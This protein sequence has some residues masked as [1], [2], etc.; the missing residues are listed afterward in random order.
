MLQTPIVS[1][2][3][4]ISIVVTNA[5]NDGIKPAY[6]PIQEALNK[7]SAAGGGTV[8][9]PPGVFNCEDNT[10]VVP[11]NVDFNGASS[12]YVNGGD[13]GSTLKFS[14]EDVICL[15]FENSFNSQLRNMSIDGTELSGANNKGIY[16]KGIWLSNI[17]QISVKG[18][19]PDKG[20]GI[21]YDTNTDYEPGVT[22][23]AQHNKITQVECADG[24]IYFSGTDDSNGVTTTVLDTIRGYK[25]GGKY[26]QLTIINGTVE[27]FIDIGYDFD[28]GAFITLI[29]PTIE[30]PGTVGVSIGSGAS[31]YIEDAVWQGFTGPTR[32]SG[33]ATDIDTYGGA[34]TNQ[35]IMSLVNPTLL[36]QAS[37]FEINGL[38]QEYIENVNLTGGTQSSAKLWKRYNNGALVTDHQFKNHLFI[39]HSIVTNSTS[40]FDVATF[41]I[42]NGHGLYF[43][44]TAEGT[45]VG[46]DQ[47]SASISAVVKRSG[48][49]LTITESA[50]LRAGSAIQVHVVDGGSG[51]AV[52]KFLPGAANVSTA[53]FTIEVRGP[54]L[55]YTLA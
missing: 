20:Y 53:N 49:V 3:D 19:P 21:Y 29:H 12:V 44:I 42:P 5:P 2:I 34:I 27:G 48:G 33:I 31:V 6:L 30:G 11:R 37:N 7:A 35:T 51:N 23:G 8:Q 17:A 10:L 55:P 25:I 16:G 32:V 50:I 47:Y 40:L 54:W 41:P 38:V 13:A 26:C 14:G 9:L 43:S 46:D 15:L 36:S 28:D 22:W 18:I 4:V 1:L 39:D 52:I 45:Q 24:Y